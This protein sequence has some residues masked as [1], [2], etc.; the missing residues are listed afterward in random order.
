MPSISAGSRHS[1]DTNRLC[2]ATRSPAATLIG[3]GKD[4]KKIRLPLFNAE[5]SKKP[6]AFIVAAINAVPSDTIEP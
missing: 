6:T 5:A 4:A 2:R 1:Q 3:L